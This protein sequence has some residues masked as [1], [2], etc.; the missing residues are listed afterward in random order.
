MGRVGSFP[1]ALGDDC[2]PESR[3]VAER[4]EQLPEES[5]QGGPL[6]LVEAPDSGGLNLHD[7]GECVRRYFLTEWSQSN[8][9]APAV[10]GIGSPLDQPGSLQSVETDR[11]ATRCD[12]LGFC[13]L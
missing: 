5:G 2:G 4:D 8:E 10:A 3:D 7:P 1:I 9:D 6:W 12:Q 11:H 13:K